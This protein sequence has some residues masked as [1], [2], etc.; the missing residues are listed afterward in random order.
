[1]HTLVLPEVAVAGHHQPA[2]RVKL[3]G[4]NAGCGSVCT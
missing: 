1:M 2:A 3:L 4:E